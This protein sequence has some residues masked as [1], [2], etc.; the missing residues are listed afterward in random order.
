VRPG[1]DAKSLAQ[2]RFGEFSQDYVTS[3]SHV[4]GEDLDRLLATAGP[5]R[6]WLM[7]DIA[8]GGGHTALKIAPHV[9]HVIATD[10]TPRMLTRARRHVV[11]QS[12]DNVTFG[13]ADA[14]DL[15]FRTGAFD[16]VT[17]RIAPH[18]FPDAG[19][20]VYECARVLK[21]GRRLVVQDHVL[22]DDEPAARY[23]DDFERQR[24]PSHNRAFSQLEWVEMFQGAGLSVEHTEKIV[25][26][27]EFIPWAE[28]Q[29]CTAAV[30]R[31]LEKM[32]Q[33][34]PPAVLEWMEPQGF[35]T[36]EARFANRHIIIIGCKEEIK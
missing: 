29:R 20:F 17:C 10:L 25:K 24:D 23:V 3:V 18:H 31:L 27:H 12:A 30:I 34:A 5:E 11:E 16:L 22:P 7:L 8:T 33:T 26:R 6:E 32:M 15:P 21:A 14:E 28:R 19:R 4:K 36:P 2:R 35:G 13:L 9:A 1:R